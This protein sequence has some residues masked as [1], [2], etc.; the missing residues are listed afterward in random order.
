[1]YEKYSEVVDHQKIEINMP[2][3]LSQWLIYDFILIL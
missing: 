1:M 3:L 2:I